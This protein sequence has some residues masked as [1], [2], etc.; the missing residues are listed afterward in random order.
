MKRNRLWIE[1]IGLGSAIAFM[2]ALL[3][4]TLGAA[5]SFTGEPAVGQEMGMPAAPPNPTA[6]SS[7]SDPQPGALRTFEGMV[8]CSQCGAKHSSKMGQ[9][10]ADCTR[11]CVHSGA[12][13]SLVDGEKIYRLEGD[14]NLLKKIAGERARVVGVAH[15]NTIQVT[16]L[17]AA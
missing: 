8:T 3:I 13:F 16:A 7:P 10:A 15:G 2:L 6:P 14:L 1:I 12:S 11:S 5:L 4:A 9:S 17:D